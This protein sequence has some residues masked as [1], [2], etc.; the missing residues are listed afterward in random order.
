[1]RKFLVSLGRCTLNQVAPSK[2]RLMLMLSQISISS[3]ILF[4]KVTGVVLGI[5]ISDIVLIPCMNLSKCD[6]IRTQPTRPVSPFIRPCKGF[7]SGT[8]G[9]YASQYISTTCLCSLQCP[10]SSLKIGGSG[11]IRTH[12]TISGSTVFKTVAI[13]RALPRFL[14]FIYP[15][16]KCCLSSLKRVLPDHASIVVSTVA[17]PFFA[18]P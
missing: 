12:G 1:M 5:I 3:V 17:D 16:Y 9:R 10:Q 14:L 11:E 8:R 6:G 18:S 4:L 7:N 2:W 15:F 13:N